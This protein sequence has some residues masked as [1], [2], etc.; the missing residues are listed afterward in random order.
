[1]LLF[2]GPAQPRSPD[3]RLAVFSSANLREWTAH[4][5]FDFPG[6]HDAPELCEL[7][8]D[9]R[10]GS[11]WCLLSRNGRYHF[12]AFDGKSVRL[13]TR[14]ELLERGPYSVAPRAAR[15]ADGRQVLL[16]LLRQDA[17]PPTH[18]ML[19]PVQVW[20]ANPASRGP[21]LRRTPIAELSAL[22]LTP[23]TWKDVALQPAVNL[24]AS[25][26]PLEVFDF[27]LELEATSDDA[28]FDL[29]VRGVPIRFDGRTKRVAVGDR[30]LPAAMSGNMLR[31]VLVVDRSSL[32]VYTGDGMHTLA[33]PLRTADRSPP[34]MTGSAARV[35]SLR[36]SELRLPT[37][38]VDR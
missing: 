20:I 5:E 19:T 3:G 25:L 1:M 12:V 8:F 28:A 26:P 33:L 27:D 35:V 10:N 36:V 11:R 30:D 22:R 32:E 21:L 16:G 34:K 37:P 29:Q 7:P 23:Q 13:E 18:Q 17:T 24:L 6:G 31:L 15:L 38:P 14:V 9:G 4:G 2:L